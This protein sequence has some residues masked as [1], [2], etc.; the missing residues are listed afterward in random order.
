MTDEDVVLLVEMMARRLVTVE[1]VAVL[2]VVLFL[3][4]DAGS[5]VMVLVL[6]VHVLRL[7]MLLLF[8]LQHYA[9]SFSFFCDKIKP[10][11]LL[12]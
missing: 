7:M 5:M 1:I 8:L 12:Q 11:A 3:M 4:V 2:L 6:K 9:R 10:L